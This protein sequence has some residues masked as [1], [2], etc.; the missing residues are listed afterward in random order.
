[1]TYGMI[2]IRYLGGSGETPL[3]PSSVIK[4]NKFSVSFRRLKRY[5]TA[6]HEKDAPA[7]IS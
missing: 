6:A 1:M 7:T 3:S 5:G 4:I 2:K